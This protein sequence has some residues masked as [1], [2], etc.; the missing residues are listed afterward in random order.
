MKILTDTHLTQTDRKVL[1]AMLEQGLTEAHTAKK[2][3]TL[4]KWDADELRGYYA[5]EIAKLDKTNS[6]LAA[7]NIVG[8][9][10]VGIVAHSLAQKYLC[11]NGVSGEVYT[12]SDNKQ[13]TLITI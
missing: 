6:Q 8:L 7:D 4:K 11:L 3:Y 2:S 12:F 9:M 10:T 5:D 13:T 1:K